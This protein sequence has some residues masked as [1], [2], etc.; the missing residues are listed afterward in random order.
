MRLLPQKTPQKKTGFIAY[1]R[2]KSE[3]FRQI[4]NFCPKIDFREKRGKIDM[5]KRKI[6]KTLAFSSL[7]LVMAAGGIFA[8]AP[9]GA[10]ANTPP[11]T[12]TTGLGLDPKNDPVVYTTESGLEIR[13][14]NANKFSDV[15]TTI[16]NKGARAPQDLRNFYYFTMGTFSGTI[17]VGDTTSNTYSL[18]NEPVNWIILG[19]G[20][21]SDAF[22]DSVSNYLFSTMKNNDY[23]FSNGEYYFDNQHETFSPAGQLIDS[24]ISAKT[25]IM[26]KV[27]D[28]IKVHTEI[29]KGCMLV[30]SER[31]LGQ[32]YFNSSGDI[33]VTT[34]GN[35]SYT[36]V[37]AN[38]SELYGNRYRYKSDSSTSGTTIW[39]NKIDGSLYTY[40]NNLFSKN[41]SGQII[42]NTLGFTEVQ[43]NLIVPQQLYTYYYDGTKDCQET[44]STDGGTYY[45][46]F[47]LAYKDANP[48]TY[49]NFC[50]EDYLTT[51]EQRVSTLIGSSNPISNFWYLRS[52]SNVGTYRSTFI[53]PGGVGPGAMNVCSSQGVRPA[54][55]MKLS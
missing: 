14:S 51:N 8:F 32:M 37:C 2:F 54:M 35:P 6:F 5:K 17:Y 12:T 41:I 1:T 52:G 20:S 25:Y 13:M 50:Y 27:K 10:S 30:I 16:S 55:V 34:A 28:S 45:T 43:A 11:P 21:H 15:V 39:N 4:L 3:N 46:M 33:N 36:V 18:L 47:P 19:V 22:V 40:I 9:I 26:G 7:A 24:T 48:S 23:L 44:P 49:Q 42:S 29:P 31:T 53:H 38:T